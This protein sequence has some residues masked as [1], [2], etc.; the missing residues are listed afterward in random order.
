METMAADGLRVLGVARAQFAT[1]PAGD[2]HDFEF[3]FLGLVGFADPIRPTVPLAI[4]E[5]YTA[6]IRVV[7]ITGDYPVTAQQIA[8]Q[9]GLRNADKVITGLEM[10]II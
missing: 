2:Q 1:A 5:C 7:M 3:D 6:G 10:N 8:R 4:K 9:I